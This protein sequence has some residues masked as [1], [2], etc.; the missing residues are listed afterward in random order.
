MKK[1]VC[2]FVEIDVDYKLL[3]SL[4]ENQVINGKCGGYCGTCVPE[5]HNGL[6]LDLLPPG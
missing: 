4:Q 1:W 3:F 2:F 5:P 6:K